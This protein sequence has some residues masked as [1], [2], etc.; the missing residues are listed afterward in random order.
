MTTIDSPTRRDP[1]APRPAADEV[2]GWSDARL[3][4]FAAMDEVHREFFDV[5]LALRDCTDETVRDAMAAFE[6][7]ARRHF[8]QEDRWM[9]ETA[10]PP[11][12]CHI[13]EHAAVLA[14]TV[15]VRE[16]I[17]QGHAG[18]A[19]AR[20]LAQHLLD[21]FPGHADYLDAALAAWMCKRAHGG[22]PVVL[23]RPGR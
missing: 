7:H 12:D 14:S 13:D 18:A 10:F 15:E 4:G 9:R 17:E 1:A 5:V 11:R 19:L 21:W 3:L 2:A 6:D 8:E 16:A 20:D 22:I 23:R